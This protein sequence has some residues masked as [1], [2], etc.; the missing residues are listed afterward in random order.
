MW[1]YPYRRFVYVNDRHLTQ[2]W[3]V[4]VL[5]IRNLCVCARVGDTIGVCAGMGGDL[6]LFWGGIDGTNFSGRPFSGKH[7]DFPQKK[8]LTTFLI[9]DCTLC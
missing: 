6:G 3:A 4:H 7:F 2:V 1:R 9:I 8:F 5:C